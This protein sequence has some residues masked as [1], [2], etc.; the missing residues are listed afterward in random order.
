MRRGWGRCAVVHRGGETRRIGSEGAADKLGEYF[1]CGVIPGVLEV[2][3]LG[4]GPP[5]KLTGRG[6]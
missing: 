2:Q 1:S 6:A 4:K 5:G 3:G